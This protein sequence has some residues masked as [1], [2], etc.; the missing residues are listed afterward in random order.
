M[1]SFSERLLVP[2]PA[3]SAEVDDAQLSEEPARQTTTRPPLP[4]QLP[5]APLALE[6]HRGMG[7]TPS[8]RVGT[9]ETPSV[10]ALAC[11]VASSGR[12]RADRQLSRTADCDPTHSHSTRDSP[13]GIEKTRCQKLESEVSDSTNFCRADFDA[14]RHQVLEQ[15]ARNNSD[16]RQRALLWEAEAREQVCNEQLQAEHTIVG[17]RSE[18]RTFAQSC[19]DELA[20]LRGQSRD[21]LLV[22]ESASQRR[23]G[24]FQAEAQ[25]AIDVLW[26]KI[27]E[28]RA[29]HVQQIVQTSNGSST[30]NAHARTHCPR[31]QGLGEHFVEQVFGDRGPDG[32]F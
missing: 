13:I 25:E 5:P 20:M 18:Q 12:E 32:Q 8:V 10:G 7:A 27:A 26:A 2:L 28:E 15:V 17:L 19:R 22:F 14:L 1:S 31:D 21:E 30:P 9:G 4:S 11:L 24:R 16:L 3:G 29:L 23:F 6:L